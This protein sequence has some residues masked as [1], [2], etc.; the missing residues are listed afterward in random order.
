MRNHRLRERRINRHRE[1]DGV[2]SYLPPLRKK[3]RRCKYGAPRFWASQQGLGRR[4]LM[5][6]MEELLVKAEAAHGH[7]CAGQILGVRMALLG[8]ERLGIAGPAGA[9]RKRLVTLCR[10]RPLRHG[11]DRDGDRLP[12]GKADAQVSRL[13][14]D[15]CD[16][17]RSRHRKGCAHRGAGKFAGTGAGA[18]FP[19]REQEPTADAGLQRTVR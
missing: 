2:S 10:N 3:Q 4:T 9:D 16:L 5:E 14:Q 11:R 17:C 19:H 1:R 7:M 6:S 8:L 12:A 18:V 15:G 13:G